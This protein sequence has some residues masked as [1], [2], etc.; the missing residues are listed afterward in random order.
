[1]MTLPALT[2]SRV[3]RAVLRLLAA[4][5]IAADAG[6][7][8]PQPATTLAGEHAQRAPVVAVFTGQFERGAPVYRLPSL[9][10][11]GR[12]SVATLDATAQKKE[13]RDARAIRTRA[14]PS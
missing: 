10:I 8:L 12:R 5:W 1:M 3:V 7:A 4:M 2:Q 11:T 13:P 9:T 6:A 14:A